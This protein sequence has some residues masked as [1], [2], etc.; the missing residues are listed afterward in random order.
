MLLV[1][2]LVGCC[3]Q[4]YRLALA[5]F[6]IA[7]QPMR[8]M[9]SRQALAGVVSSWTADP[10]ADRLLLSSVLLTMGFVGLV[11]LPA[12]GARRA[13]RRRERR[14]RLPGAHRQNSLRAAGEQTE[15]GRP[16]GVRAGLTPPPCLAV[17][18][19]GALHVLGAVIVATTILSGVDYG[20]AGDVAPG[21]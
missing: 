15:Y 17:P 11:P 6:V 13:R 10:A 20:G 2:P 14:A 12:G 16:A 8:S 5:L 1:P 9:A 18:S 7:V 19:E 4:D 21:R 3:P